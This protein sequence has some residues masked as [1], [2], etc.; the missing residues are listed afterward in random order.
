MVCLSEKHI[1]THRHVQYATLGKEDFELV[2][3]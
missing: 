2:A 3:S 1:H